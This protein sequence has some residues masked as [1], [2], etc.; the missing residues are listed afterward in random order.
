MI[1][2]II[3]HNAI[4]TI[5]AVDAHDRDPPKT[6]LISVCLSIA[7]SVFLASSVFART[8][9][10]AIMRCWLYGPCAPH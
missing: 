5:A 10:P 8:R 7:C 2:E 4:K 9:G 6:A 3:L 1:D